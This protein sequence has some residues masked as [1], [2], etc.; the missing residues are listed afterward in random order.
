LRSAEFSLKPDGETWTSTVTKATYPV[1]WKITVPKLGLDLDVKTRL[2]SQELTGAASNGT[3]TPSYWEGAV[4][5]DGTRSGA[6]I[7]GAGY[8]EMTGYDRPFEMG[9]D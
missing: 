7:Q 1:Q 5:Y 4:S 6:K 8:L 2:A 3:L 9:S